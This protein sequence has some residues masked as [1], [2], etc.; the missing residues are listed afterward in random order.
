[1]RLNHFKTGSRLAAAF[2]LV[3]VV[4]SLVVVLAVL[5]LDA[6]RHALDHQAGAIHRREML[7][8]QWAADIRLNMVR[9]L[10]I[11]HSRD[12]AYVQALQRET[13][14]TSRRIGE[15]AA[16]VAESAP[17]AEA[18]QHI[19]QVV[20]ARGRYSALR[21]QLFAAR[22][23]GATLDAAQEAALTA[24]AGAYLQ[25]L[26]RVTDEI[27]AD[28]DAHRARTLDALQA[29]RLMILAGGLVAVL[30]GGLGSLLVTRSITRPVR[31][32]SAAAEAVAAGDLSRPVDSSGRDET[33]ALLRSLEAMRA[34]LAQ[35]VGEVRGNADAL[36]SASREIAAGSND[37]ATRTERQASALEQT[38]AAMEQLNTT[39]GHNAEHAQTAST[40]A[41]QACDMAGEGGTVVTQVVQAMRG[42]ADGAGR[43]AEITGVIDGIA[44]QT[45]ILA[46]NAAVEAA[47]AGEQGRGFAVV[48]GEVRALAQRS[49]EAAR[50]IKQLIG[51]SVE[52]VAR[53]ASLADQ[54]GQTMEAVVA[55][56]RGV[57]DVA[58]QISAA[59]REQSLGVAQV[60]EAVVQMDQATQQNAA[61]VE[62]L[63]AAAAALQ[64]QAEQLVHS[65]AVFRLG[66]AD[67]AAAA[68]ATTGAALARTAGAAMPAP[69]QRLAGPA[70][71]AARG[72]GAANGW[73]SF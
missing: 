52:S 23:G 37:L 26:Q 68:T 56:I 18:R 32:A 22:A 61:V 17:D 11:L 10:A 31:G 35:V 4:T 62:Q 47:R 7:A 29:T 13:Q 12:E 63:S 24:Q 21:E 39:V 28:G 15:M 44:F 60:G 14:A 48:A 19:D 9:S 73:E 36:A 69:P 49:A 65:V 33:A 25:A 54:A 67:M 45:N 8:E 2:L 5:R 51:V 41:R 34:R 6:L 42:I 1:M 55:S 30:V 57:A 38:A 50:E 53:G 43:I 58:A 20:A 46:L 71:P 70:A 66:A 40:L 72:A 16:Q 64:A 27:R 59:S 3:L